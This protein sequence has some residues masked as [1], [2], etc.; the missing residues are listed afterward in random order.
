MQ[1]K[2][3][4]YGLVLVCILLAGA[5]YGCTGKETDTADFTFHSAV[6][7]MTREEVQNI[8]GLSGTAAENGPNVI[9]ENTEYMG[10]KVTAGLSFDD[11]EDSTTYG[12]Y[13]IVLKYQDEDEQTLITSME[14]V[15]GERK[16]SFNDK[17]GMENPIS[18]AGWVSSETLE[19][20][21]SEKEIEKLKELYPNVEKTRMDA[22]LR[23]PLVKITLSEEENIVTFSGSAASTAASLKRSV[24]E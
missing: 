16:S 14:R 7:G 11:N 15:Y 9:V 23:Q 1:R 22:V 6:W 2:I 20:A 10:V 17:N 21:L 24:T 18:P 5:F 8:A 4:L 19:E 13:Q 12:L 3:S